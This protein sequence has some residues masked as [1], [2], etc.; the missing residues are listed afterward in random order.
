[1]CFRR[2]KLENNKRPEIRSENTLWFSVFFVFGNYNHSCLICF[3]SRQTQKAVELINL[4]YAKILN[5][6]QFEIANKYSG[7]AFLKNPGHY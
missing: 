5:E 6:L 7:F 4:Y 3:Y 1:M 2:E